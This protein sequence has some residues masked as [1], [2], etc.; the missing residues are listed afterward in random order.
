MK[1][2]IKYSLLIVIILGLFI[3][4]EDPDAIRLPD[5]KDA[6]NVRVVI[7]P[8]YTF[9]DFENLENAKFVFDAY[10]ENTDLR[11]ATFYMSYYDL[12]EDSTYNEVPIEFT[13]FPK[14]HYEYTSQELAAIFN[15]PGGIDDLDGGDLFN[16]RTEA[17]TAEGITYPDTV[18][19]GLS[20]ETL[21]VT[22]NIINAAA[23][24][25][26]TTVFNT[27]VGCPSNL[28]GTYATVVNGESTDDC[29]TTNP[30]VDLEST[31]TFTRTGPTNYSLTNFASGAYDY[32][33]CDAYDLCSDTFDG[34]PA[35]LL[36]ICG[37]VQL[38]A[39]YWGSTGTGTVDPNTG[40]ITINWENA[41]GD[42]GTTVYT[43]Q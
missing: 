1:N 43:P 5:F 18:L 39:G 16:F 7:D 41:F 36:D 15:L 4:C 30:V 6:V 38:S 11:S 31:V 26:F 23:T 29:C 19:Q 34:L 21:N 35:Q 40:V 28:E 25:S 37:N 17:V 20:Q 24:T 42:N 14:Q 3:S 22:P 12:S 10:T 33:Y 27:F 8:D 32:W 13:D 9:L 2:T